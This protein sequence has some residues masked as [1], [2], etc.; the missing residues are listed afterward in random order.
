MDPLISELSERIRQAG[1]QKRSLRIRGGGTK[2]FYAFKLEGE[3]L[4]LSGYR[5]IVDYEPSELVLTARAGT[6]LAEIED[7]LARSGQMLACEPPY[8]GPNATLGGCVA[9]GFSG[10]RRAAAGSVRDFVLGT[11]VLNGAGQDLRFGGQVMKNV[12]G[13]DVSRLMTG[14]FGTLGVI[15]EA[16]L[17]VLPRPEDEAT[18]RFQL[19]AADAIEAMN[20]W[21]AQPL[22]ISAT[23]HVGGALTV[24]V[25]GSKLGVAAA[26][27]KIGGELVPEGQAFW[28]AVREQTLDAFRGPLWRLSIKSTTPPLAL[29]GKQVIEWNGSLRWIATDAPAQQV[30]EVARQAGGHATRFRVNNGTPMIRLDPA[31]LE[32]HKRLKAALDPDGIFGPRRLHP[33]F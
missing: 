27:A 32:L 28:R 16:S 17:K 26:R 24:R 4:D 5:G 7:A 6:P 21:A 20:R 29:P 3:P 10:P 9:A 31:V 8:F 13:F 19:N 1:A 11:R 30:F 18:L 23:C 33:D 12:A 2:D 14:S 22:P 15:L 25:S